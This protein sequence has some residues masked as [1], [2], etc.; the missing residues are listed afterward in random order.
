MWEH[1]AM[2]EHMS[3]E[4]FRAAGY[5]LI[6]WLVAYRE[7]IEDRPVYPNVEPGD[8][9]ALIPDSA[10]EEGESFDQLM[11]DLDRVVM[12][13]VTHWQSP[14]WFAYFPANTSPPSVLAEMASAGLGLQGMLWSTSPVVT[15]LEARVLDWLVDLMGLPDHWKSTGRGGGVIQMSASDAT[16]AVLVV[17][18]HRNVERGHAE[19]MVVYVSDQAHSSIEKGCNVAGIGHCRKIAVDTEYAM[20]VDTLATAID[21]DIAQGLI[22]IAVVSS[23]GT[24][25]T[26]AVDPI[27]A[28]GEVA[29]RHGLWHHVD[30]A[31]AGTAMICDEFLVYQPGLEV[32]DSYTFNPHKWM[33]VNFDCNV[34]WVADRRSLIDTMSILPPYL[35][36]EASETGEVIDYRDW[37]VPLG[38]RFRSLKLWWV[39]RWYGAEGIRSMVREHVRLADEFAARVDT[40][41]RFDLFA[42]HPFGLV[43]FT[44]RDGND[45]TRSLAQALNESGKVAVTA[46]NIEGVDFIR[47]AIGQT[48]TGERHVTALWDMID[49]LA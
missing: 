31:Y 5:A 34:L 11:A 37:H 45:A 12:P 39:L 19:D 24:T 22:P 38:R 1:A 27:D 20:H 17:A 21:A 13:G 14:N 25:G 2:I 44:H 49:E 29:Q 43:C 8:I 36:N 3:P 35:R 40:D 4:E 48:Y 7:S 47:I 41:D 9:A 42:P 46:S 26:T 6:D 15:E 10:P 33:M 23:V 32:V 16:H 18:R 28:I 30:A